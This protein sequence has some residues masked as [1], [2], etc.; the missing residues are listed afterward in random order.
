MG[1]PGGV[2]SDH[3]VPVMVLYMFPLQECRGRCPGVGALDEPPA[4]AVAAVVRVHCTGSVLEG[5]LMVWSG[6]T[7]RTRWSRIISRSA[8]I[9]H[10]YY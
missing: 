6:V 9:S 7:T 1:P 2:G 10:C 5:P 4:D 3:P 8:S